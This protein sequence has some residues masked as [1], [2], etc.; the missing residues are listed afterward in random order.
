MGI[1]CVVVAP[2]LIPVKPG[3][4]VKTDRRDAIKLARLYRAGEL[5]MVWVPSEEMEAVRDLMR[6]REDVRRDRTSAR[7]RLHKFLLRHGLHFTE[8]RNWT[9]RHWRWILAHRFERLG[10]QLTFEHYVDQLQDLDARIHR[11]NTQVLEIAKSEPF[12]ERVERLCTLRGIATL[13][14]MVILTELVDLRR[15]TSPRQLMSFVGLTPSEHSSGEK[16]RRGAITKAG[17]A[18]VRRALVEA[19]WTYRH[20]PRMS[21]R[22]RAAIA[23]QPPAVASIARAATERLGRRYKKLIG[24]GKKSQTAVVAVA[25]ELCGFIWALEVNAAA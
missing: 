19:S 1:D 6:A 10:E 13:N 14:A 25:R 4:H 15:F 24:R 22:Q 20:G 2:S 7:H 5:T 12:R 3:A 17:N 9:Q 11:L 23:E 16:H 18:H 21:A 8:G